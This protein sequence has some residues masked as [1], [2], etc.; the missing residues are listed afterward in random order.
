MDQPLTRKQRRLLKKQE[1]AQTHASAVSKG[2]RAGLVIR[3]LIA[4]G[5][6]VVVV[7]GVRWISATTPEQTTYTDQPVHWHEAFEVDL[8]GKKQDFSSYGAGEH[9][10]GL[11][12][13]H[14]HG[15]GVI[16]IE[17]RII[18]KED[19][20]L[21]KFFDAIN[22]PFDHDRIMD[23]K[24]GDTCVVGGTPGQ[25]KMFVNG[26]PNNEF[27]NYIPKPTENGEDQ[28]IRISFE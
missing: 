1:R 18:Q 2:V 3:L 16:H 10:A 21:G 5:L 8:C 9:H 6:I 23:K 13:I 22:I 14:T 17:G 19:V 25:V 4:V 11:P 28:K 20:A 27:R 7:Y 24:N 15:D 12:L 26:E